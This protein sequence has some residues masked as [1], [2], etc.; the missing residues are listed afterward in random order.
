[1]SLK[2]IL[3]FRNLQKI[4]KA[5]NIDRLNRL[6]LRLLHGDQL[7]D[8]SIS[9]EL[10]KFFG[11]EHSLNQNSAEYAE[12]LALARRAYAPAKKLP[13]HQQL[14]LAET[15]YQKSLNL[16]HLRE[17]ADRGTGA[18]QV[19][20]I[21][22]SRTTPQCQQMNGRIFRIPA[23]QKEIPNQHDLVRSEDWW[24]NAGHFKGVSTGE[25]IPS[26]PPYHYNCRTRIVPYLYDKEYQGFDRLPQDHPV[27]PTV[28]KDRLQ[29][30]ELEPKHLPEIIAKAQSGT[31]KKGELENH[32]AKHKNHFSTPFS[33]ANNYAAAAF[34]LLDAPTTIFCLR[35][36]GNQLILYAMQPAPKSK[37]GAWYFAV[38]DLQEAVIKSYFK[39]KAKDI[40]AIL[41]GNSEYKHFVFAH[42]TKTL[43]LEELMKQEDIDQ[44]LAE[45]EELFTIDMYEDAVRIIKNKDD[46]DLQV[47]A[48]SITSDRCDTLHILIQADMLSPDELK[49]IKTVD[50][51][52]L[53]HP[54]PHRLETL[55]AWLMGVAQHADAARKGAVE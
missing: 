36:E 22:D 26:L 35:D 51:Y 49:R 43:K 3:R 41:D 16:F 55:K 53:E 39:N 8:Q 18:V 42:I 40:K 34:A 24:Q 21:I 7:S 1:M 27:Y 4:A 52:I 54:V 37:S 47:Y 31:W 45:L 48:P 38:F 20:A 13:E 5:A 10:E 25:I 12:I 30:Y 6:L 15:L 46:D 44:A 50:D 28:L 32:F 23:L 11:A 19:R 33:S 2:Q 29:N 14:S 9:A 17:Y